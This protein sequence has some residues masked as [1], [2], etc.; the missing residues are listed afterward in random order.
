M[1]K[2]PYSSEIET[3]SEGN[4]HI[5]LHQGSDGED[6]V[7][8][9][10]QTALGKAPK[11]LTIEL[12]GHGA[13]TTDLCLALFEILKIGKK[14]S[15]Q[16]LVK[17]NSSLLDGSVL[18]LCAADRVEFA[19][20]R[21]VRIASFERFREILE[22][23]KE[24]AG[25]VE[26]VDENASLSEYGEILQ[27]LNEFLPVEEFFDQ[28]VPIGKLAEYFG[29]DDENELKRMFSQEEVSNGLNTPPMP[30]KG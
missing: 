29:E 6:G 5:S 2:R 13:L 30:S 11:L 7:Y 12:I 15:T 25:V 21:F 1:R 17:V 9:R 28:Q 20:H 4:I 27:I 16:V 10:I 24:S 18:L 26:D 8:R 19:P 14:P 23:C 3:D 22:K